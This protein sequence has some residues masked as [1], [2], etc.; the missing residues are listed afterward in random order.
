MAWVFDAPSGVFK[1][2]ALSASIR[3]EAIQN[4]EFM[5]FA[6]PERGFGKNKGQSVTITRVLQLPLAGKVSETDRLPSGRPA[7]QTLQ[8]TVAEWGFK[9]EIT[10]FERDLSHFDITNQFQ[11]MLRDQ[12]KLTMD[13]M[14]ADV[15]KAAVVGSIKYTPTS[16]TTGTFDT[17]GVVSTQAT[18]NLTVGH[19][20]EIH[21]R[22]AGEQKAPRVGGKYIGILSTKAA[23]GIKSDPEYREWLKSSTSAPFTS[24]N[25]V[26]VEGF[27]LI[28]T[29]NFNSLS[30]GI[31]LN[32][33]LGEAVFFGD[34]AVALAEV[35]SPELR[36]GLPEDLGRFREIGWV[37]EL[38]AGLI[39]PTAAL[40]RVIHVSST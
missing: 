18:V 20:R 37:G 4:T 29:N 16:P 13:K 21:D 2:H 12:L 7:V 39:W 19:L 25:L 40:A 3:A 38:D 27:H 22:L 14:V 23:R 1:D 9:T 11:R 24:G 31:G 6:R 30:N 36:A 8:I 32:S 35:L 5:V 26:D 28:E 10:A 33:I 17:D 34:D 15:M